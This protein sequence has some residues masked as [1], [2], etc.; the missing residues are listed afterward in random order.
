MPLSATEIPSPK[1]V[2]KAPL[3]PPA[4]TWP[5]GDHCH[6]KAYC[7]LHIHGLTELQ[8][9]LEVNLIRSVCADEEPKG[10]SG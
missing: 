9:P 5:P 6:L 8:L 10:Q 7:V 3:S 2:P 1:I 4:P